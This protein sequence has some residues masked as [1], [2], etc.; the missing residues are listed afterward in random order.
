MKAW[1]TGA[2]QIAAD[3]VA[4][5]VEDAIPVLLEHLGV[6]VEARVAELGDLA[7]EEFDP[8]GRVAE[9]DGLVDLELP[10]TVLIS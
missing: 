8:V 7:G 6:R 5:I 2:D 10:T 4:E 9:D 3:A 1:R